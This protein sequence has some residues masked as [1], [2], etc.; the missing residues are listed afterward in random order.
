[1]KIRIAFEIESALGP[2]NE[3]RPAGGREEREKVHGQGSKHSP[4]K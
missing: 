1:M 3:T 4:T 2:L